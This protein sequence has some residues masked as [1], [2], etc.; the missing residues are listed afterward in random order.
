MKVK[1]SKSNTSKT[2][3]SIPV[4]IWVAELFRTQCGIV[5][6]K[7]NS[8]KGPRQSPSRFLIK[9]AIDKIE[10]LHDIVDGK[11]KRRF[12]TEYVKRLKSEC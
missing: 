11:K 5:Y 7:S 3:I 2:V 10:S 12:D 1:T 4:P 9:S 8:E 6:P